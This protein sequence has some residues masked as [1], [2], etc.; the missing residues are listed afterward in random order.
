ML[1][2]ADILNKMQN[3]SNNQALYNILHVHTHVVCKSNTYF[4]NNNVFL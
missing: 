1:Q 2:S 4:L 3:Y